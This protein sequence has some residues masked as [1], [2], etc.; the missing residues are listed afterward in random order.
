MRRKVLPNVKHGEASSYQKGCRCDLCKN[1]KRL[2][3][4]KWIG[5]YVEN[6][7]RFGDWNNLPFVNR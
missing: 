2:H 5:K 1:A 4:R 7:K 6:P 3:V